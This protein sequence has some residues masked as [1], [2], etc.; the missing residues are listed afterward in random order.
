MKRR[1]VER[2]IGRSGTGL[3]VTALTMWV[4]AG[5]VVDAY[6]AQR[7]R[8]GTIV[9]KGS[10]YY[11]HLMQMGQEWREAPDGGA[12]LTVYPDGRMGGEE[13]MIRRIRNGQL[14]AGLLTTVGISKIEPMVDGLQ[15]MPMMFDSL[16]EVDYIGEILQPELES[17]L[18][19]KGFVVLFWTDT[20]WIR[21]FSSKPV[22]Y[23]DD[24]RA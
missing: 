3:M 20:G 5:H 19:E 6:S 1:F 24:L 23:P 15:S 18:E 2:T 22:V 14:Q 9:P 7:I 21:F 11:N 12:Q 4:W 8:L 13:E 17:S 10:S 16:D